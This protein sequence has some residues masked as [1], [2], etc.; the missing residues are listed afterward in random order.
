M[1][2]IRKFYHDIIKVWANEIRLI[3]KDKGILIFLFLLPLAYPIVYALIYNPELAREV[4]V[5]VVDECRSTQ[6]RE[7]VRMM[8]ASENTQLAG[9]AADMQEA[10]LMVAEKKAYGIL[11]IDSHFSKNIAR[12]EQAH[13]TLF[14]DMSLLVRYKSMLTSL[15]DATMT[16]G[17]KIQVETI[18]RLGADGPKIPATVR[19][20]YVALGNPEQG[21]ATFLL[22]GILTLIVQQSLILAICMMGGAIYER[23]RRNGGIDP[24]DTVNSGAVCRLL[25]KSLAYI[26]I[27]IIPLLYLLLIVPA[28]FKYPQVG[29]FIDILLMSIPYMLSVTFL[30][31][32]LQVFVRERESA[33]LVIVFTSIIFLFLSGITWPLFDMDPS[34][35]FLSGCCPSTWA[36]QAFERINANGASIADIGLEYQMLWLLSAVYFFLALAVNKFSRYGMLYQLSHRKH[37]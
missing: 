34:F 7:L 1:D 23:R 26:V 31:M 35:R 37:A 33:F 24:L 19:S 20:T 6:S 36:M 13:V 9:Y 30:G 17:G 29:G 28:I 18:G 11:L 12:G 27:Y 15:T 10:R 14:C 3:F 5:A 32:T 22:P 25:G 2:S 16:L 8:D 4:P 21:F